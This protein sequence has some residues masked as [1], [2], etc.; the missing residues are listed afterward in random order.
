[1]RPLLIGQAPGPRSDPL[2]P[3]AGRCGARLAGLCGI[4]QAEFLERFER[5]NLLDR[6]PG[7][8]GK[9]DRFDINKARKKAIDLLLFG[10]MENRRVVMLGANVARTFGF[11]P[12]TEQLLW[13][14]TDGGGFHVAFCPHPSGVSRWW[15]EKTNVAKALLFW[16]ELAEGG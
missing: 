11:P 2:E 9:G 12:A 15:N 6:F 4:E 8:A 1:M 16:R 10:Q 13:S 14:V 3:L 7:K 5:V